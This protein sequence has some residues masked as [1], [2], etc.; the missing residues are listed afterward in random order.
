MIIN[1]YRYEMR[2]Q[3]WPTFEVNVVTSQPLS[4][5]HFQHNLMESSGTGFHCV[6]GVCHGERRWR[7]LKFV[8]GRRKRFSVDIDIY[9]YTIHTYIH[10]YIS[11]SL[12]ASNFPVSP[13]KKRIPFRGRAIALR[14][15]RPRTL[16]RFPATVVEYILTS[17]VKKRPPYLPSLWK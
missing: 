3:G 6:Y 12:E 8:C 2:K 14:S 4:A 13:A 15:L 1:S 10:T 9:I 7:K 11:I 16:P 17:Q 5:R